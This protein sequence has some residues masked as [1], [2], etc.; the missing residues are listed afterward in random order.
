ML[1]QQNEGKVSQE[2]NLNEVLTGHTFF[3]LFWHPSFQNS[4]AM[5]QMG[6]GL[7][8]H[9]LHLFWAGRHLPRHGHTS[10]RRMSA[11]HQVLY[12]GQDGD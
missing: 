2:K 4:L 11:I 1:Q 12:N 6:G 3:S 5:F 10:W 8:D 7:G 9:G